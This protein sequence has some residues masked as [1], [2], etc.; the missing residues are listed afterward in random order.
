MQTNS[1]R[2]G[3]VEMDTGFSTGYCSLVGRFPIKLS[4]I[5]PYRYLQLPVKKIG[6][7]WR[8]LFFAALKS[9]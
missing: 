9:H 7:K 4:S 8:L 6:V 5:E 1:P 3:E 2:Q